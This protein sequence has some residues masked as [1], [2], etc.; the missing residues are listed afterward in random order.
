MG[1]LLSVL[2][3]FQSALWI[4]S[5]FQGSAQVAKATGYFTDAVGV[6]SAVTPLIQQFGAGKEVTAD[7]VRAALA[8]MHTALSAFDDE[9]AKQEAA[10]AGKK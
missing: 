6:I 1:A 7:D 8:G 3:M 10:E 9:I 5:A 2:P 4:V